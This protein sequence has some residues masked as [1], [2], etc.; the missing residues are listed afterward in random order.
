M[1]TDFLNTLS[2]V[3]KVLYKSAYQFTERYCNGTPEECHA[4]GLKKIKDTHKLASKKEVW[5]DITTGRKVRGQ[6]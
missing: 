3:D 2:G 1:N 6:F 5:V 4:E